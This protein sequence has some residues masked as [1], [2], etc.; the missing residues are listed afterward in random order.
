M[1]TRFLGFVVFCLMLVACGN[2][3][4][5]PSLDGG[6]GGFGGSS[7][8]SSSVSSTSSVS[9]SSSGAPLPLSCEGNVLAM[10]PLD[11]EGGTNYH[12]HGVHTCRRFGPGEYSLARIQWRMGGP[13]QFA[14]LATWAVA[15]WSTTTGFSFAPAILVPESYNIPLGSVKVGPGDGLFVCAILSVKTPAARSCLDG[16]SATGDPDSFWGDT[17]PDGTVI[18]PPQLESLSVSP[19]VAEAAAWGNDK[20]RLMIEA[21]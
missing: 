1:V 18:V 2:G 6:I 17:G 14:P 19:T 15:P 5:L 7:A 21:K 20:I 3:L 10:A 16:C 13:C 8:E 9:S 4:P 11:G 12:E